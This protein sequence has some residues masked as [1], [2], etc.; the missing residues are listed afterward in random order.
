AQKIALNALSSALMVGLHRVHGCWMVDMRAAN[1]KLRRRALA[2]A[3]H[4]GRATP[5]A[6]Q[7][8]LQ[9]CGGELK[10]ALLMLRTGLDAAAARELLRRCDGHLR[11]ALAESGIQDD[12]GVP[13]SKT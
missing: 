9:A 10:P 3:E 4:L 5:E 12:E 8:A 1:A 2:L 11:Q 13:P 6:A 7:A